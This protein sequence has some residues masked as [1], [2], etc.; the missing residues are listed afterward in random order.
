MA[1]DG[2]G[3]QGMD[4]L[5]SQLQ[6]LR[7]ELAADQELRALEASTT[8]AAADDFTSN[9]N[10]LQEQASSAAETH[11]KD[12]TET[13]SKEQKNAMA[14]IDSPSKSPLGSRRTSVT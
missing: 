7:C 14:K 4:S 10:S 11:S 13:H 12:R 1:S 8:A 2:S 5:T 9:V 6:Q 3:K